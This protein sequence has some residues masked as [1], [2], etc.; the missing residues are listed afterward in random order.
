MQALLSQL[1]EALETTG[2]SLDQVLD[3]V[4]QLVLVDI[5]ERLKRLADNLGVSF[6]REL[7]RV[8]NA[9]DTMLAAIPLGGDR[10]AASAAVGT[11]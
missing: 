9:F 1:R 11:P 10:H 6:D 7:D 4:E 5:L 2:Q 8:R 3:R